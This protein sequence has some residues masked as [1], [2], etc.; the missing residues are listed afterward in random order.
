[1]SYSCLTG[2]SG[3]PEPSALHQPPA[4][5]LVHQFR[6]LCQPEQAAAAAAAVSPTAGADCAGAA[7]SMVFSTPA[8]PCRLSANTHQIFSS[9][10]SSASHNASLFPCLP[11]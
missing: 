9:Q 11:V 1:M 8:E 2:L 7:P 6:A 4:N 3:A 5:L 10:N